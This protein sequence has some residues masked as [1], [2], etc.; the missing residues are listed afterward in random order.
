LKTTAIIISFNRPK[1]TLDC[2]TTLNKCFPNIKI[3]IGNNGYTEHDS[4]CVDSFIQ[5][6]I[7]WKMIKYGGRYV[8]LPFDCGIGYAR[9][10]LLR[11]VDTPYVLIGD[12][13]FYYTPEA[14]LYD[15]ETFL[16]NHTE[17]GMVGGRVRQNNKIMDYQGYLSVGEK[18]SYTKLPANKLLYNFCEPSQLRYCQVDMMTNCWIGRVNKLPPYNENHKIYH[19]HLAYMI[20]LKDKVKMAFSPDIVIDHKKYNYKYQEYNSFRF[21]EDE[22]NYLIEQYGGIS[23]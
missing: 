19:E 8:E 11:L 7:K 3:L 16:D 23:S 1:Y 4:N 5:K 21:R 14:R 12:D 6:Q 18:V 2:I 9:N 15:A 17:Y 20:G 13:D 10:V 22:K